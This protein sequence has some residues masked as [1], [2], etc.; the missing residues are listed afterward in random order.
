M[1]CIWEV[2]FIHYPN[3]RIGGEIKVINLRNLPYVAMPLQWQCFST[4]VPRRICVPSYL[5]MSMKVFKSNHIF[6]SLVYFFTPRCAASLKG[7]EPLWA[8]PL[9][10]RQAKANLM[11]FRECWEI[12]IWHNHLTNSFF[13]QPSFHSW[14]RAG[15]IECQEKLSKVHYYSECL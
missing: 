15:K 2:E 13:V 10:S 1:H 14:N 7:W 3:E 11:V 9:K 5:E 8:I 4:R 12:R 6:F